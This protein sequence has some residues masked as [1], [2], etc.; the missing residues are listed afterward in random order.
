MMDLLTFI[1]NQIQSTYE[2][3]YFEKAPQDTLYPYVVFHLP[4]ISEVEVREDIVLEVDIWTNTGDIAELET[5]TD[6]VDKKLNR[7]PN[8][9]DNFQCKIYRDT[10]YRLTLPD[11][12]E[13]IDRRRLRY[14]IKLYR[15]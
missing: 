3:T 9:D 5:I 14:N 10:P 7:L 1:Y 12:D 13:T 4:N 8:L 6:N 11:Q 15:R 2:K